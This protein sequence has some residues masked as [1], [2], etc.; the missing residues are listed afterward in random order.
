M[1]LKPLFT[2]YFNRLYCINMSYMKRIPK[3]IFG[4]LLLL[5]FNVSA[6]SAQI[7]DELLF[8]DSPLSED[9]YLPDWFSLS[10]RPQRQS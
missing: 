4:L 9:L 10:F 3:P 2:E 5:S 8:D 7:E 6:A 1:Y